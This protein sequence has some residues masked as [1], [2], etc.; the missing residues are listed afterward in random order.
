[1]PSFL[2]DAFFKNTSAQKAWR[3]DKTSFGPLFAA[4]AEYAGRNTALYKPHPF[5]PSDSV[6]W[7]SED[8]MNRIK[9]LRK[10]AEPDPE[11]PEMFYQ[12]APDSRR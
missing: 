3:E 12:R 4:F 5:N 1:M 9:G 7:S 2:D 8:R 11:Q 6:R 10:T